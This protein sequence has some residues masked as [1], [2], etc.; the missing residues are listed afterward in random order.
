MSDDVD[1][2][3]A[4]ADDAKAEIRAQWSNVQAEGRRSVSWTRQQA[5]RSTP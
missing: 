5:L 1:W 2:E 3:F 4:G